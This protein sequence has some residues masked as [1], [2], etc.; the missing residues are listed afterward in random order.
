MNNYVHRTWKNGESIS[1]EEVLAIKDA[2]VK[3]L[4]LNGVAGDEIGRVR[5]ELGL[6]AGGAG[7]R[8]LR[9][10]NLKPLSRR[11]IREIL[12]R[13]AGTLNAYAALQVRRVQRLRPH[14]A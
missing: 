14:A 1:H 7:D 9:E 11:Q 8:S 13:N 10:G 12:D 3:A 5:R 2:F 4:A 6:A